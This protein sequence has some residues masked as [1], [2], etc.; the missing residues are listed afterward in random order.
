MKTTK[1]MLT[2]G[3]LLVSFNALGC[4]M[5]TDDEEAVEHTDA[6]EEAIINGTIE[7]SAALR[8]VSLVISITPDANTYHVPNLCTGTLIASAWVLTAAHCV[9]DSLDGRPLAPSQFSVVGVGPVSS[10]HVMPGWIGKPAIPLPGVADIALLRLAT[11]ML[12]QLN[13]SGLPCPQVDATHGCEVTTIEPYF[14][15]SWPWPG[16][17]IHCVSNGPRTAGGAF[18]TIADGVDFIEDN[19]NFKAASPW[20]TYTANAAGQALIQSDEGGACFGE[21]WSGNIRGTLFSVNSFDSSEFTGPYHPPPVV[22]ATTSNYF[23][24]WVKSVIPAQEQLVVRRRGGN[25]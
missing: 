3:A 24:N 8:A 5:A 9:S 20:Y 18:S 4:A 11:P 16:S 17:K 14:P 15:G 6:S 2:V 21:V 23:I 7:P 1:M 10:V 25:L 13:T 22:Y 12:G 19:A